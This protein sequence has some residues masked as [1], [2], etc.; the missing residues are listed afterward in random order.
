MNAL[1]GKGEEIFLFRCFRGWDNPEWYKKEKFTT[2]F[3]KPGDF[4]HNSDLIRKLVI[5]N[6]IQVC[7]FD[8]AEAI[9]IQGKY[10]RDISKVCWE[11]HNVNHVLQS[12]LRA[13]SE[14]INKAI[15]IERNAS[16]IA[17]LLLV[18]SET[19][20]QELIDIGIS[21]QKVALYR[22]SINAKEI[23]FKLV[24]DG[25]NIIFIGNLKYKPNENAVR[26]ISKI[27]APLVISR[28]PDVKFLIA[29]P[30]NLQLQ[31]ECISSK[32][33]V[34]LGEVED[35]GQLYDY[36]TVALCPVLEGSGT[37]I[38]ILEYLAAGIPTISTS[39]GIEGLEKNIKNL[40][41]VE[42]NIKKFPDLIYKIISRPKIYNNMT[43]LARRFILKN[44]C[45][46]I[47]IQDV[48]DA[49]KSIVLKVPVSD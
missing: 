26:L 20:K 6:K 10:L 42:D 40:L 34:F 12:R 47:T 43:N 5:K 31:K 8:S 2:I 25:K 36:A 13:D 4:Y 30:L 35:L 46:D 15:R 9:L 23:N 44:R 45:W 14:S 48:I 33:I 41:I 17:N 22:G 32:N 7:H 3:I 11:V 38:K 28:Y 24:R 21:S 37:R 29:G 16:D 19:D 49:Y 27:I 18:R 1:M 39:I